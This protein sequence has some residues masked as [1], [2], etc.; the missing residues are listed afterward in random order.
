MIKTIDNEKIL[1]TINQSLNFL[2]KHYK[3]SSQGGGWYHYLD[4]SF[5]AGPTASAVGLMA[6]SLFDI[7]F[8][9]KNE[10]LNFLSH[11]QILSSGDIKKDGGWPIS[12]TGNQP[13]MEASGWIIRSL[14]KLNSSRIIKAPNIQEAYKWLINNQ[15]KDNGWGSF[16]GQESRVY[17]TCM[18]LRALV[19]LN[20]E[21]ENIKN[22]RNW[23]Y[24]NMCEDFPA[25]G[26]TLYSSPTVLHT[27]FVLMTLHEI[28]LGSEYKLINDA[29]EWL[30]DNLDTTQLWEPI[31]QVEDYDI[32]YI[33]DGEQI[34][35]Q[36]SLPHFALPVA[37]SA[38]IYRFG[39]NHKKIFDCVDTII[40]NQ[41]LGYWTNARN[42]A[43]PSI[44]AI[45]P[46]LQALNDLITIPLIS[47]NKEIF[48][49]RNNLII[50]PSCSYIPLFFLLIIDGVI[51][52][53]KII[54][55][56]W[57]WL[58]LVLYLIGGLIFLKIGQLS[59][60]EYLLALLVPL[61]L[62]FIQLA[63]EKSK[64]GRIK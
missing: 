8:E 55:S 51:T 34:K 29:Y 43:R 39:I 1:Y 37:L 31:S 57:S 46:F 13:V 41:N 28:G 9:H 2:K 18:A 17:L 26:A 6:F 61:M 64:K 10:V 45:W 27:G 47:P 12:M 60:K 63:L 35:Y 58:L 3:E 20:P 49:I 14:G 59:L 36:N 50:K 16:F 23:L 44:W 30:I 32:L 56:I 33:N 54:R 4:D 62:V 48:N 22:G 15:N 11:K 5:P 52:F 38:L 7:P 19:T 25:W 24:R 40:K 21:S 53:A 42:P